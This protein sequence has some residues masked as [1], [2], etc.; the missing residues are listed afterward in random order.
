MLVINSNLGPCTVFDIPVRPFIAL[1]FPSKIASKPL[2]TETWL[3][4]T[5]YRKLSPPYPM[6]PSQTS[7]EIS[8]IHNTARLA[9][10]RPSAL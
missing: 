4:L 6:V 7:Y 1:N 5:A 3:L 9:Y 2:Q 10:Y 8:F